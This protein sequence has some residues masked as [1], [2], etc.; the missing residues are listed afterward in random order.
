MAGRHPDGWP[1][2]AHL[3]STCNFEQIHPLALRPATGKPSQC[4]VAA[5]RPVWGRAAGGRRRAPR[6]DKVLAPSSSDPFLILR[7][8]ASARQR[9]ARE[10][11]CTS[12]QRQLARPSCERR[13][14]SS[15]ASSTEP[16]RCR[17]P[18]A[19]GAF[20]LQRPRRAARPPGP[21][22]GPF[23]APTSRKTAA[24][25]PR[26]APQPS[27]TSWKVRGR[28]P[29]A[30]RPRASQP[31]RAPRQQRPLGARGTPPQWP[32]ARPAPPRAPMAPPHTPQPCG[33]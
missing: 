14:R 25:R 23:A 9:A 20:A 21:R 32:V 22:A 24:P 29:A 6:A 17:L 12:A 19:T 5:A 16:S 31:P 10:T 27:G 7:H 3:R 18:S 2:P 8:S 4:S 30:A 26:P 28:Q 15:A 33:P 1:C 13:P 11:P